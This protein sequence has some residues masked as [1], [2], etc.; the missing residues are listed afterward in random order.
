MN[1]PEAEPGFTPTGI[2]NDFASPGDWARLYRLRGIQVVPAFMPGEHASWKRPLLKSWTEFQ[3]ALVPDEV[4]L[5]WYGVGGQYT[6][7]P[8]MGMITGR[9]S[10]NL[11]VIDL[12][13]HKSAA[14]A[15]WWTALMAVHN[16]SM[17]LETVEQRTGGGGSQ[18]L[19]RAP[20]GWTAPTCKT[21]IGVDIRGQGG[22]AMLAPSKHESGRDYEWLEGQ[23]PDD[24]PVRTLTADEMWLL[25][26]VE[27]LVR[28]HG[29]VTGG[30]GATPHEA[31][32]GVYDPLSGRQ[33]DGRE[34]YMR[35]LIWAAVTGYRKEC[36]IPIGANEKLKV[37]QDYLRHVHPQ[38]S[39]PGEPPEEALE[40][41]GRGYSEFTTKW[42]RATGKWSTEIEQAARERTARE[43]ENVPRETK[44]PEVDP[45]TGRPA[46]IPLHS[47]F[48]IVE[49]DIPVRDWVIPGLLLRRNLSVLVAPPASGKSLLTLQMAI[50][51]ALGMAWG[52]WF[53][54]RPEKV[55]VINAEDDLDEMRRRLFAAAKNMGVNQAD[56]VGRVFLADAPE[57]IVIARMDA[58]SK[59]VIRTPLIEQLVITIEANGIGLVVV[60]PFAE[61]FE[62]DENSNSEVKWAGI[63]WREVARRT[64][65]A[66]WLV[67]HTKKYAGEM[68]GVADASR[69]GGALIGTARILSTL[70]TMTEDEAK[71][72][73]VSP[74]DRDEY[75]RFDDAKANHSAKSHVKWFRKVTV[76][77]NNGSGL[78]PGDDVGV[79]QPWKP[80]GVMDGVTS[81]EL[82]LAMESIERG[83]LGDDG[84]PTG[85]LFGP[86]TQSKDRWAGKVLMTL[87]DISED[88]AKEMLKAWFKS[89]VLYVEDYEDP[90]QRKVRQ[91]VKFDPSKRP[92]EAPK[93][94]E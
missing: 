67:H 58:R 48:P 65:T 79:L 74:E 62:G 92:D 80:P 51:V 25:E 20:P 32:Q 85:Q 54:R 91:G 18:K 28:Q 11:F 23:S 72:L 93:V 16:N 44:Q 43:A 21:S 33:I 8:N 35:D 1:P 38:T 9:A 37:W 14:A 81:R 61:T 17:D 63:I 30:N 88:K 10:N 57:S 42:D 24:I 68:A 55:L 86:T 19:Y 69:G 15:A 60:D 84:R 75:V 7:R 4:F 13:H 3:E 82:G 70:F 59:S 41:E 40:R 50:A 66:L 71:L 29:G 53:P 77:L 34:T 89:G 49:G 52:G 31:P 87:L 27:E 64:L 90:Q 73:D 39:R 46:P 6:T 56:L 45:A 47:A 83:V 94:F 78:V 12:D 36:P 26:A 76:S 22:F 5:P 2:D